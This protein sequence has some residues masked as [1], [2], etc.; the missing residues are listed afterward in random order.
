MAPSAPWRA[1]NP[2]W[3]AAST[4]E[5]LLSVLKDAN[6]NRGARAGAAVCL[7]G[8]GASSRAKVRIAAEDVAAPELR[9]AIEAALAEDEEALDPGARRP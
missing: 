1:T 2:L 4:D 9:A 3:V 8:A 5:E 6:A 7:A